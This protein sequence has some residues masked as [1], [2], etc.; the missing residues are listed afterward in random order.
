MKHF[1]LLAVVLAGGL[2]WQGQPAQAGWVEFFFPSLRDTSNDPSE[3]LVAPFADD[4]DAAAR[5]VRENGGKVQS[6]NVVNT[7]PLEQPHLKNEVIADWVMAAVSE[8]LN[9]SGENYK[10]DL[11]AVSAHF[12]PGGFSE[13]EAFL[14][15]NKMTDVLQSS[16]YKI[17]A[18]VREIPLLLNEG[19]VN[20]RYRWLY[21]VP[22]MVSYMK[23][24]VVDY[25][26]VEPVNQHFML[27]VQVGRSQDIK[28]DLAVHIERWSGTAIE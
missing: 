17:H 20:K 6:A 10:A 14:K 15:A 5:A 9:F 2:F 21:Q 18:Y 8:A 3:T 26:G 22:V 19:P 23:K 12:D 4:A 25:K 7:V 27:R 16:Q 28:N 11:D 13:F 1:V 24:D